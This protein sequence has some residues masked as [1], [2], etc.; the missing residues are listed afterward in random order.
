MIYVDASVVLAWIFGEAQRPSREFWDGPRFASR[1]TELEVRVRSAAKQL[2]A[3]GAEGVDAITSRLRFTEISTE[4]VGLLYSN[5][6]KHLRTLDAIHLATLEYLRRAGRELT[7]ATY[8]RRLATAAE[9]MG[10][11]VIVP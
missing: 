9:A 5:P 11:Q 4:T 1:L 7:L 10:F 8:D 3:Q 2:S 6:P